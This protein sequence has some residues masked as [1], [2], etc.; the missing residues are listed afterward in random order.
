[1]IFVSNASLRALSRETGQC[2]ST[3]FFHFPR[4]VHMCFSYQLTSHSIAFNF[5]AYLHPKLMRTCRRL[6]NRVSFS[7]VLRVKIQPLFTRASTRS[8]CKELRRIST[9]RTC[10]LR[11]ERRLLSCRDVKFNNAQ[12][13]LRCLP[14]ISLTNPIAFSRATPVHNTCPPRSRLAKRISSLNFAG[15]R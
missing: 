2:L 9:S 14:V 10:T 3:L 1:M 6:S 13:L 11:F 8:R 15:G 5:L 12:S 4:T 7:L